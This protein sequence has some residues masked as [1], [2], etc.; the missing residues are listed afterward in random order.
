[1]DDLCEASPRVIFLILWHETESF[2]VSLGICL[3]QKQENTLG[4]ESKRE[5]HFALVG[6]LPMNPAVV[7]QS[8]AHNLPCTLL[9][10]LP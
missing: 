3:G 5:G 1:M 8:T 2:S 6:V 10:Y 4:F 9:K 7:N